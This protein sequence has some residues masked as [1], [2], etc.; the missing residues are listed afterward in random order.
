MKKLVLLL[1]VP[2]L[3]GACSSKNL[4]TQE[5]RDLKPAC[6]G[7]DAGVCADIGHQ[8]ADMGTVNG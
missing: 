5:L 8:V 7:G 3:I 6:A 2:L 1:C 4:P